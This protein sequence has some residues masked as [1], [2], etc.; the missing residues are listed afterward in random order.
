MLSR[1]DAMGGSMP[2]EFDGDLAGAVFWGADPA[3]LSSKRRN[4]ASSPTTMMRSL[5]TKEEKRA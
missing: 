3:A 1:S 2:E 5:G 4:R